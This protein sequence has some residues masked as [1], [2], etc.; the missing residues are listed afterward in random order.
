MMQLHFR[1]YVGPI[2][3]LRP[4]K[5][6][7]SAC[8]VSFLLVTTT[9][10]S[11]AIADLNSDRQALLAFAASVPHLR[12]LNWNSTNHICK[13]WVGVTCTSDGLSVHALRLPG[14]GLLGPIPPNTLGKLES[15]RILSL[16]SNLLSG[17]LPPDIHSLP[18]LDYI[19][20]QHN[21]FS[22][23]VPSFVS[24]QLNILDLSF[25]SFTGKIP[26]TF[27]NLKQLTGLSLQNNKLSGPVPNLDTV[28]LRRLNLSNNHLNGSIPSALGGFPSSS[29]SG[30]TLLCG[31]PLQPC[32]ISSPPPS[33]TPHISTPPLP[34]FPHKEGSKRKLHVSTIIP[35]AAG[36]AALLLLITVVILCCCIK[37]KDKR[38]DSIV[39]VKTLT[40]KAKQE[41]GSGVQEPEKNKL[42]FFNGCSYNFDL[43][44]LLR[45]SAEVLG[46]GSYGTAYKA[47]LEES[48]TVVVKRLK[49]VAA[50]KR[51][52][53]QQ[54]EII[55][56]V[57]NHPSVVPLRAYYYSKDEKL[58]VCDYYPAGNLSSLL[59]GNRGSEKTPLDWDSR[60]KITLSAAKGIAHLHAVGGPKFSH[61]NIKSSNVIMKQ[62]SDACISDFG[63]TPLMAVP[64]APM[65]GAGY[66]APEVM[67]TRKHTH[68]SDV[69]SFGVLILEMLTGKSPV[70][71]PS[72][73]DM[74][75]LPRWVQSVVREEWT[76]E[77][78]D[79]ELMRFQNIEE[80]MVQMLQ[81]AMACVAQ[82]PEVRPTM[83]D[84]VRMIEEIRVSDSETTRPSSDDNSKPKDSNVQ[85]QITP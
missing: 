55:S 14:I 54:M 9:F 32:A 67:E 18:S 2:F 64:I 63:L 6:F 4:S 17:N 21:N 22:G 5:G 46:K 60:V 58:M 39:K 24:P 51:E 78:F 37:K 26:A 3:A 44:D 61:G 19:F 73:D 29:F 15:L 40:E 12:R 84:V 11:F 42:V 75:D 31:L 83:D 70:Q 65:R 53:E 16:R 79:V 25:N 49:E 38:E 77:V 47:V 35:I 13:S 43:E 72:R 20:L 82:M 8:L 45:A 52:F 62:E 69:Y 59:H 56:W 81:I 27:Q 36:G 30:N 68:K 50:G 28:S 41:F 85:V 23:E 33:L 80:E 71:S 66:R 10:C 1:I 74:V 57:G 7:L 34:P 48:T 76:S